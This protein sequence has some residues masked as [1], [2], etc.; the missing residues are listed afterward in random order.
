MIAMKFE[1]EIA[2]IADYVLAAP[3]FSERAWQTARWCLLDSLGC[4]LAA[5][6]NP[7][8]QHLLG[9]R[10]GGQGEVPIVG[11]VLTADPM[12]AAFNN[13]LLIRWLDYNDTW[14]A[15]EWGHPSDNLGAI[16]VAAIWQG[17]MTL[18]DVAAA[19]IKA[20]E[21]QGVLAL[22]NSFNQRGFDHVLLV[23]LA[24]T[25]VVT[26]MLG[27][28]HQQVCAAISH[29]LVDGQA[30]RTYRHAP[31]VGP[32]KS[33]AS[34]DACARAWQIA[35]WVLA[36][37][38]G[39]AT[40]LSAPK[41]GFQEVVL[42]GQPLLRERDYDCYV[43]ENI[44]FKVAFPA[45]F[46]GQTAVECALKL[47]PQVRDQLDQIQTIEIKTQRAAMDIINKTGALTNVADRDHSLQYMVAVGLIYGELTAEHYEA[48]VAANGLIDQLRE[49]M[50]VT[51]DEAMTRD[52]Y[53]P[54]KR[55]IA[56][57]LRVVFADGRDT[58]WTQCDYPLGHRRRRDE[59]LPLLREKF[60][61]HAEARLAARATDAMQ[62]LDEPDALFWA[63][64]VNAFLPAFLLM[65]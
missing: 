3:H 20:Y 57:A 36:G 19:M 62:M 45:E 4:A 48:A 41:W 50:I 9:N 12:Q 64:S 13:G 56:N 47:H 55:A 31:N 32:R 2:A 39:Y 11:T 27:G 52:Y 63:R 7:H 18:R 29:A 61:R 8:C 25:A 22:K 53:D 10:V 38:P 49:K 6:D 28:N 59:A 30:L 35:Q 43:M 37:E 46:H 44:L 1:P 24:A 14:L 5:S 17:Q 40:A 60:R 34:G 54:D 26:A 58:G 65:S 33:W 15:A 21:I 42:A 51:E 23:K 16:L